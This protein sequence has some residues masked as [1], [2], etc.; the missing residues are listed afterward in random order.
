MIRERV[1][2]PIS[3][4]EIEPYRIR[5]REDYEKYGRPGN[6]K[7]RP[8]PSTSTGSATNHHHAGSLHH[9]YHCLDYLRQTIMC[10]ADATLEH[11]DDGKG[12][13]GW[14]DTHRCGDWD[15]LSKWSYDNRANS[16]KTGIH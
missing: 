13:P 16:S 4:D 12:A 11:I 5:L 2:L 1:A 9:V 6:G 8:Y 3:P 14:G 15:A 7:T 10:L